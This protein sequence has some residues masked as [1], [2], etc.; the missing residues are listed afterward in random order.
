MASQDEIII[1]V[2]VN[3]GESAQALADVQRKIAEVKDSQKELKNEQKA[4]NSALKENGQLTS[5]QAE[6]LAEI[7]AEMANNAANLKQLN[8]EEKMHTAQLNVATQGEREYGDSLVE[9]SAQL[10]QL[11]GE[12]RGLSAAQ[13]ESAQGQELLNSIKNLDKQLKD[14]DSSMG[15]FQRNVGN[16]QSALLGLNGNVLK[17]SNLFAGGFKNGIAAAG[18]SVKSFGKTL[19]ATPVGQVSAAINVLLRVFNMLRQAFKSNDDASTELSA[20]FNSLKPIVTAVKNVF[21]ELAS[22]IAKVVGAVTSV[23]TAVVSFLVPSFKEA[24]EA[25]AELTRAQDKLED[26]RR[27]FSTNEVLRDKEIAE[28]RKKAVSD[29]TLSAAQR[30]EIYKQIDELSRQNMEDRKR[31]AEENYRILEAEA[32]QNA[33]TSDEMKDKLTE[34]YNAMIKAQTEYL[35]ETVRIGSREAQARK[36]QA[37]EVAEQAKQEQERRRQAHEAWKKQQAERQRLLDVERNEM[38]KLEDLQNSMIENELERARA[39]IKTD[40]GRQV[41]DIKRRL[42]TEKNLTEETRSALNQQVELLERQMWQKL[43]EIDE[44]ELAANEQR[45]SEMTETAARKAEEAAKKAAEATE[46][47]RQRIRSQY[48]EESQKAANEFAE[49]ANKV[50]GSAVELSQIEMELAEQNYNTLLEMD[51]AT[52]AALFDNEEQYKAA[53]LQAENEMMTARQANN[54]A[55]QTQAK[56]TA[57]VMSAV[58]GAMSSMFEAVAGDSEEYA[59]FKKAMAIVDAAISL[60]Q[61]IAAATTQSTLGDPYTMAIRIAANVAAVTA[62]FAAVISAIKAATIPSAPKFAQGGIVP[63]SSYSGDKV[64]ARLNSGEMILTK[65]QQANLFKMIQ[66]G[67]PSAVIDYKAIAEAM[68]RAVSEMPQPVLE[69]K[70]FAEF[71]Q[72]IKY[73]NHKIK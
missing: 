31:I 6:R 45:L 12:Y 13:R 63:G 37:K 25:A 11:K 53:V 27:E 14:A 19:L 32:K 48:E 70:E 17:V 39:E 52:K 24:S 56:E 57:S 23:A 54:E 22:V 7:S 69:Y 35:N 41:E 73:A 29:E 55:L 30:E 72:R 46:K 9:L 36:E 5:Q 43:A 10:A 59:K 20:A 33:D 26:S 51:T 49:R 18:A 28:L 3:A 65:E 62:Q 61:T 66:T 64:T 71:Q 1:E 8:A 4:L 47:E 40:Y 67:T 21:V 42:E 38:R 2:K 68:S 16:Y 50:F 44:A 34:A 60:A 15:D 58:T